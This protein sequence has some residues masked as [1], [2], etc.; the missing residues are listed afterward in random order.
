MPHYLRK[1]GSSVVFS[2]I[3]I[4]CWLYIVKVFLFVDTNVLDFYLMSKASCIYGVSNTT[5]NS[6]RKFLYRKILIFLVV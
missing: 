3:Y 4:S 5:D 1:I 2:Y 6:Q